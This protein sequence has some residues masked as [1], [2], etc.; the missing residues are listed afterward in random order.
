MVQIASHDA[1]R[2]SVRR[3]N[4]ERSSYSATAFLSTG[5]EKLGQPV[6]ESNWSRTRTAACRSTHANVPE[7]S[8]LSGLENARSVPCCRVTR[9]CSGV[10]CF[11]TRRPISRPCTCD[12]C[13]CPFLALLNPARRNTWVRMHRQ[14]ESLI[15]RTDG[16]R[17]SSL[18]DT[19]EI[20]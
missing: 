12:C 4:H 13:R 15:V 19:S 9:Y 2:P 1:Q 10:S 5:A 3:M 11:S 14:P 20:V 17:R 7:H 8:L 18:F 16:S 6:P